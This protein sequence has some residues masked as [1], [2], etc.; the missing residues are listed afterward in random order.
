MDSHLPTNN[1]TTVVLDPKGSG[2]FYPG[3]PLTADDKTLSLPDCELLSKLGSGGMGTVF[4]ARQ[5]RL[6]RLVA[7]KVVKLADSDD[8]RHA[9][10]LRDE[11][12]TMA[13]LNHPNIVTIYDMV[14]SGGHLFVVMEY[15]P[16]RKSVRDL[17]LRYGPL[18][19]PIVMR[20]LLDVC[21]GLAYVK[22]QDF[23]HCDL[24]PDNILI[25]NEF[26]TIHPSLDEMFSKSTTRV[27][28]CDFGIARHIRSVGLMADCSD[29]IVLGS[30]NYMAPEQILDDR[31]VDFRAD[32]Y[33]LAGT[34][35]FMLTGQPPFQ[36]DSC[37]ELFKYKLSHDLPC[38][39]HRTGAYLPA[40][41]VSILDKM[42][43]LDAGERYDDYARLIADL[44]DVNSLLPNSLQSS[45]R[46]LLRKFRITRFI[47]V[48]LLLLGFV[49]G[50]FALNRFIQEKY[51]HE[52]F[53]S[54]AASL[55]F[56]RQS[57]DSGWH[58]F[59]KHTHGVSPILFSGSHSSALTLLPR[60]SPGSTLELKCRGGA[61]FSSTIFR[62]SDG[63]S[64]FDA[65]LLWRYL[66]AS[67][68][69][70][71]AFDM[72]GKHV[73][74]DDVIDASAA[75]WIS[76]KFVFEAKSILVYLNNEL[77]YVARCP[78][79]PTCSFSLTVDSKSGVCFRDIFIYPSH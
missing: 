14:Q 70:L 11:A 50:A 18:P 53:I 46:S 49:I 2:L 60:L 79:I 68:A 25:A 57:G 45:S 12:Q 67:N 41:L 7:V 33:S 42:G 74:I 23:I 9:N 4:L 24:K 62:F 17:V 40:R 51:F 27:K 35:F 77:V 29:H 47:L 31:E 6:N 16:G 15:V 38:L 55:G 30:P 56:W 75:T 61:S 73:P 63:N 36:F 76:C 48:F 65:S 1:D 78:A 64:Q 39:S 28:I 59:G 54:M 37:E 10:W 19:L 69:N 5:K 44:E 32:I 20:I 26:D 22:S 52:R 34:V 71:F 58:V 72:R 21:Y 8:E 13:A 66:P 43:R 3:H